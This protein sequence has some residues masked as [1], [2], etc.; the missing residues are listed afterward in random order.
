MIKKTLLL[1]SM[2]FMISCSNLKKSER[3]LTSGNY[4]QAID[5][6]LNYLRK[7]RYGKKATKHHKLLFE[8][9][10]K[11]VDRDKRALSYY[12]QD[13]N[14]ENL[15]KIY[16]TYLTLEQRQK[17]IRPILPINNY[18]FETENYTQN[19]IGSR[20]NLSE[21]LYQK[22]NRNLSSSNVNLIREAH[23]DFKYIQQINPNY[24][25]TINLIG[26]SHY[27]GTDFVLIDF[28][29]NTNKVIPRNLEN[30]LLNLDSYKLDNYW[31]EYHSRQQKDTTYNYKMILSFDDIFV[32]PEKI[33]EVYISKEK[34]I[35][36]GKK[37]V[38]DK[39]G[40]V[41]KD[42][43]GNDIKVDKKVVVKSRIHQYTQFKQAVVTAKA[44]FIDQ[45]TR[46]VVSSI[47]FESSFIFE[48][49]HATQKGDKRALDKKFINILSRKHIPFPTNSE[50]IY[51]TGEDIKNQLQHILTKQQF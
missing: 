39:D 23:G 2:I 36:D 8:S 35:V 28:R 27:K 40:N 3:H 34:E 1:F 10:T 43:N 16:N 44:V 46:K 20:N 22:A 6:S 48:H 30:N 7:N 47:P 11:A 21:Y 32:S 38:L 50:M 49:T 37:Y 51:D 5:V 45:T 42:E 24:K 9:Y 25:N 29:N 4:D 26:E 15:E 41:K 31:T 19:I 18:Y 17:K 14:P 33:K 13:K 12:E